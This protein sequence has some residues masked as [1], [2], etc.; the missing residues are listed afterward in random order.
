M[1][2]SSRKTELLEEKNAAVFFLMIVVWSFLPS[3]FHEPPSLKWNDKLRVASSEFWVVRCHFQ[4][5]NLRIQSYFFRVTV[6]KEQMYESHSCFTS[7]KLVGS[8]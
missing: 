3:L 2:E 7:W 6:L 1:Y 4:K 8:L 5:I